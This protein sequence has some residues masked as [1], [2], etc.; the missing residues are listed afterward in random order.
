MTKDQA[1]YILATITVRIEYQRCLYRP[2]S[3]LVT[4]MPHAMPARG[5]TRRQAFPQ[6]QRTESGRASDGRARG[7]GA[8]RLGSG[9]SGS[10]RR[11]R[12][13]M[14]GAQGSTALLSARAEASQAAA[15]KLCRACHRLAARRDGPPRRAA[16]RTV[17][18]DP[19]SSCCRSRARRGAP[20]AQASTGIA[21]HA[22]GPPACR[23]LGA[24]R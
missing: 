24:A 12:A 18:P 5:P 7:R 9:A 19:S 23:A 13:R 17:R 8:R 16:A 2:W 3:H 10:R 15:W 14:E 21:S 22:A 6:A 20:C 4:Q 11:P 1:L